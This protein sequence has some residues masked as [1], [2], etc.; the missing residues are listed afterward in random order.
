MEAIVSLTK[1]D[2]MK[3]LNSDDYFVFKQ[4]DYD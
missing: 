2:F 1:E 3:V 4:E